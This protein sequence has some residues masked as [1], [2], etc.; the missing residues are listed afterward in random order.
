MI[1]IRISPSF[2]GSW[3]CRILIKRESHGYILAKEPVLGKTD[4][5]RVP[6]VYGI[7][8]S[9]RAAGALN[10]TLARTRRR[11]ASASTCGSE[12]VTARVRRVRRSSC[13][14]HPPR[15]TLPFAISLSLPLSATFVP[16]TVL[17]PQSHVLFFFPLFLSL[18]RLSGNGVSRVETSLQ[19]ISYRTSR[20]NFKSVY[21]AFYV[22][23]YVKFLLNFEK[24]FSNVF[25]VE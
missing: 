1:T 3:T 7:W 22:E 5:K 21:V 23:S 17:V 4:I 16:F 20:I 8:W 11:F 25:R 10:A 13:P 24:I 14:L 18:S 6:P 2:Y 19:T 9:Y 15:R 12:S